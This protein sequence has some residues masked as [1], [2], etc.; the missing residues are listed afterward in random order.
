MTYA[1]RIR[2]SLGPSMIRS[3]MRV[4]RHRVRSTE[5]AV[6]LRRDLDVPHTPPSAA[7]DITVRPLTDAEVPKVFDTADAPSSDDVLVQTR[8]RWL[9]ESGLG[10]C[11]AAVTADDEPCY[12]QWL[13][14]AQQNARI[15]SYF[16][17]AF[18]V[19]G[20]GTALLEGAFTPPAFRG[21]G[22]MGAAMSL[23]AEKASDL[24]S[25]YVITVVGTD[26]VPS[27]KGCHKANFFPY[28]HRDVTWHMLRRTTRFEPIDAQ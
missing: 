19:L 13:M 17:G 12:V 7:I 14:G 8:R 11:Y 9:M 21:K 3:S 23:I 1:T 22:I 15:Q 16:G 10:T 28:M 6:V 20:P 25:R 27:L 26:N 24:D 2:A 4:A 5:H 18:P